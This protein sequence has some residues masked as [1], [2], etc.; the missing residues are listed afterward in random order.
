MSGGFELLPGLLVQVSPQAGGLVPDGRGET[1][2]AVRGR[3]TTQHV[4]TGPTVAPELDRPRVCLISNDEGTVIEEREDDRGLRGGGWQVKGVAGKVRRDNAR[5]G[6][7][8]H[9]EDGRRRQH[10]Q[11]PLRRCKSAQSRPFLR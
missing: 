8:V 4:V 9:R 10:P 3:P 6:R 5:A 2:E 11:R 1:L 7:L